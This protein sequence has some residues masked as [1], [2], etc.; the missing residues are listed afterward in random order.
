[1]PNYVA[2]YEAQ[3][4]NASYSSEFCV[5]P[6]D[7]IRCNYVTV[8]ATNISLALKIPMGYSKYI[9]NV[10]CRDDYADKTQLTAEEIR[11]ETCLEKPLAVTAFAEEVTMTAPSGCRNRN[12]DVVQRGIYEGKI[13]IVYKWYMDTAEREGEL[14]IAQGKLTTTVR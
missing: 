5:F 11:A 7:Y 10:I 1:M 2:N 6:D 4:H 13:F 14:G 12:G 9:C 3:L 8:N